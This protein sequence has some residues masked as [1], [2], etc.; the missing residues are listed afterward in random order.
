MIVPDEVDDLAQRY[1]TPLRRTHNVQADAYIH[2]YRFAK[3]IDRRAEVVFA[4]EDS[5]GRLWVHAK[6]HYPANI[7]RLPSGGVHWD[8]L[9]TEALTREIC[10]E[11]GLAVEVR[12]FLGI[13]EYRFWHGNVM[14][15]FVSYVFHLQS[16]GNVPIAQEGEEISA[17]RAVLPKQVGQIAFDLRSLPGERQ[18]WGQWRALAHDLVYDTLVN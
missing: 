6:P 17:F 3:V 13:I 10:E 18:G 4:V 5:A 1:G 7:F 8:E 14:A 15:P 11:M 16:R 12:R 9:V 2:G